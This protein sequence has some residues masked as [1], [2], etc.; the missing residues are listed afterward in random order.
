MNVVNKGIYLDEES[1]EDNGDWIGWI[2]FEEGNSREWQRGH[3][4]LSHC[5]LNDV[6]VVNFCFRILF[7]SIKDFNMV[8]LRSRE[9]FALILFFIRFIFLRSSM[10]WGECFGFMILNMLLGGS[11]VFEIGALFVER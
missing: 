1:E 6:I 9:R 7:S 4:C 3:N 5:C 10:Y 2:C 8:F 11:A